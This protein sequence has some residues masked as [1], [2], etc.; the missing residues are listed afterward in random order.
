MIKLDLQ[1][2]IQLPVSRPEAVSLAK[3]GFVSSVE[4]R[5]A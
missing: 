3:D 2:T 5:A 1:D 4:L